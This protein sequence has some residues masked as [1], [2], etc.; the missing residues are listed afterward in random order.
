MHQKY[1]NELSTAHVPGYGCKNLNVNINSVSYTKSYDC[2]SMSIN[3]ILKR[4]NP[5]VKIK[6]IPVMIMVV[7]CDSTGTSE[8]IIKLQH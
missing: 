6:I 2:V 3:S 5:I 7:E 4:L 8:M 1:S